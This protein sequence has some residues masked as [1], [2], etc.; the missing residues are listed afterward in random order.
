MGKIPFHWSP[1]QLGHKLHPSVRFWQPDPQT[2][3]SQAMISNQ[4]GEADLDP[5]EKRCVIP[6]PVTPG[7]IGHL[8]PHSAI[9]S[10]AKQG[11]LTPCHPPH[12]RKLRMHQAHSKPAVCHSSSDCTS[13]ND[14]FVFSNRSSFPK[15]PSMAAWHL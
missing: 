6:C 13:T 9:Q 15:L 11:Q 4:Q 1:A 7:D 8:S 14:T 3:R 10:H 2:G 5:K 12:L